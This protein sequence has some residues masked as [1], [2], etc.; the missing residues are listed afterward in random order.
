MGWRAAQKGGPAGCT[1]GQASGL[2]IKLACGKGQAGE[3]PHP[4]LQPFFTPPFSATGR[5]AFLCSPPKVHIFHLETRLSSPPSP[6]IS[7]IL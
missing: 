4:F 5:T 7:V 2:H 6:L 3:L 1:T